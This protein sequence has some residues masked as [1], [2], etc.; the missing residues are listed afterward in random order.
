MVKVIERCKK[1]RLWCDRCHSL[2]EFS[3]AEDVKSGEKDYITYDYM[4]AKRTFYYIECPV[5]GNRIEV[6]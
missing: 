1:E 4:S 5:C 3:R 2:L 6:F